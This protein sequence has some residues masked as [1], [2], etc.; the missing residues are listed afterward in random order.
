[1]VNER[2]LRS[3]PRRG[4][5]DDVRDMYVRVRKPC[6]HADLVLDGLPFFSQPRTQIS[7]IV[8]G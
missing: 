4:T 8:Q 2:I 6:H 5:I 7:E 1:M 3:S